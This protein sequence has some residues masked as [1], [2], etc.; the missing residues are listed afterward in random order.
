MNRK[1][2]Q[3]DNMQKAIDYGIDIE[4]LKA[5][6]KRTPAERIRRHQAALDLVRRL[7]KAKKI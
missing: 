6:L 3:P 1:S 5:N 2:T 4:M 7:Q